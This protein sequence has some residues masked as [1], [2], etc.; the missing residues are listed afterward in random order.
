MKVLTKD[1]LSW[2]SINFLRTGLNGRRGEGV[3]RLPQTVKK[4]KQLIKRP[5][6][7]SSKYLSAKGCIGKRTEGASHLFGGGTLAIYRY[8]GQ[9][10]RKKVIQSASACGLLTFLIFQHTGS[11]PGNLEGGIGGSKGQKGGGRSDVGPDRQDGRS[12]PEKTERLSLT[13]ATG[14]GR[15]PC[16]MTDRRTRS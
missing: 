15:F 9:G 16:R 8:S 10:L 5:G 14:R 3:L 13:G 1:V 6:F 11:R 4:V 12:L 2:D 7:S